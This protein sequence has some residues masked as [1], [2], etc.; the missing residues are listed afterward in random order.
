MTDDK[1]WIPVR[2]FHFGN[3][4]LAELDCNWN[5]YLIQTKV[6]REHNVTF[7]P[8]IIDDMNPLGSVLTDVPID[9]PLVDFDYRDD[10][11]PTPGTCIQNPYNDEFYMFERFVC[12]GPLS[13]QKTHAMYKKLP[14]THNFSNEYFLTT[15]STGRGSFAYRSPLYDFDLKPRFTSAYLPPLY[16]IRAV[17]SSA[18]PNGQDSVLTRNQLWGR[19]YTIHNLLAYQA[20]GLSLDFINNLFGMH[21]ILAV[22]GIGEEQ[23]SH[24]TVL[25]ESEDLQSFYIGFKEKL[26]AESDH[27][28]TELGRAHCL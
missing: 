5:Q 24:Y 23:P 25:R 26:S 6:D 7:T 19:M 8:L 3:P 4:A 17:C 20:I 9:C 11:C 28:K 22:I 10:V 2:A 18:L 21:G 12:S 13:T 16:E 15:F 1:L 27:F 14:Y